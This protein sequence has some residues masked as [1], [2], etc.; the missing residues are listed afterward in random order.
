ML[1]AGFTD[2]DRDGLLGQS[3]IA[4]DAQGRVTGQGG[5]VTQR[6]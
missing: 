4:V 1:E 5:Y 2:D 3:P 6:S